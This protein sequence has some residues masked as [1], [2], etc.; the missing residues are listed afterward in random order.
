MGIKKSLTFI[1]GF[2]CATAL[3]AAVAVFAQNNGLFY[4]K[5]QHRIPINLTIGLLNADGQQS[6]TNVALFVD[7]E[8]TTTISN[9]T[10]ILNNLAVAASARANDDTAISLV[11]GQPQQNFMGVIQLTPAPLQ[12]IAAQNRPASEQN[13]QQPAAQPPTMPP[14][15]PPT[16]PPSP[17]QPP[18]NTPAPL[19][20]NTSVP[21]TVPPPPTQPPTNTPAPLPTNTPAPLPTNTLVPSPTNT[22]GPPPTNTPAPIRPPTT[23]RNAN[24]RTGPGVTYEWMLTAPRGSVIEIVGVNP[25]RDWYA[26]RNGGWV[27]AF[28]ID[29]VPDDL[30]VIA[31]SPTPTIP[32]TATSIPPTATSVP[33][34]ATSVPPTATDMPVPPTATNTPIPILPPTNTPIPILPPTNTPVPPPTNTSA[35]TSAPTDV[36]TDVPTVTYPPTSTYQRN[37]TSSRSFTYADSHRD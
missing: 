22:Q 19:P 21:P 15:Q 17:T 2:I 33:P 4:V 14:T 13:V 5:T 26:L 9:T 28:L 3:F 16:V 6:N 35:P 34:T 30:P 8:S 10:A 11:V 23:N 37:I 1:L 12:N 25:N 29:N 36:P 27:A 32:P 24:V 7:I 20:T 31:P 18:T